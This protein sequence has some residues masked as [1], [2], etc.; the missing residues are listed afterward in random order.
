MTLSNSVLLG[1]LLVAGL[2]VLFNTVMLWAIVTTNR[3]EGA[4]VAETSKADPRT[5]G[6]AAEDSL[7]SGGERVAKGRQRRRR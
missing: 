6:E 3:D 7:L 1:I 4:S 5:N 2:I